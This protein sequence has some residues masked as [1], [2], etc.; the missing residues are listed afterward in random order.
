MG[1]SSSHPKA[2]SPHATGWVQRRMAQR[3][4]GSTSGELQTWFLDLPGTD[5][6]TTKSQRLKDVVTGQE[7]GMCGGKLKVIST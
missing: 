2:R 7:V 1:N 4:G 5:S 6:R 3:T